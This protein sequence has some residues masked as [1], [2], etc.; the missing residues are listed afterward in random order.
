MI[1]VVGIFD[2][3]RDLRRKLIRYIRHHN[4]N[5]K[6]IKWTYTDVSHRIAGPSSSVT[7]H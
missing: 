5:P 7:G 3:T 4:E 1:K 6:P 2:S